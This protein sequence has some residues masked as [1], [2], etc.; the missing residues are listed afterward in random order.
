SRLAQYLQ[1]AHAAVLA[2][3]FAEAV[4]VAPGVAHKDSVQGLVTQE[5]MPH[6]AKDT[7]QKY[8]IQKPFGY[9]TQQKDPTEASPIA[10]I[11]MSGA[12]PRARDVQSLWSHLL[13]GRDCIS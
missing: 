13:E 8:R 11:G 9:A 7:K 10:I 4:P 2:P 12:F 5:E 3:Y 1:V 6:T